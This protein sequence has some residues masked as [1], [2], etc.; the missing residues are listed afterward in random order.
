MDLKSWTAL[1]LA[2]LGSGL[3]SAQQA[4]V[5]PRRAAL[6]EFSDAIE[7]LA[8][9]ASPAVV[10]LTVRGRGPVEDGSAKQA[11]FVAEQRATGSGVI[12]D[13]AGYIMTNAHVV[14]EARSIDVSMIVAGAGARPGDHKH[15]PGQLVGIDPE[16]DLALVKVDG[17]GFPTLSFAD[18]T[19][20][21]Q[22]QLVMAIG[23]PLGLDNT[24]TVGYISAPVRHLDPVKPMFYIQTDAAINPGNSGG[25]L[26]DLQGRLVGINTMIMTQSGGSEGLGFAIPG[27]IVRRVY[28]GLRRDGTIKRGAIGVIPQ[29]ISPALATALGLDHDSGVILSD[30]VPHGAAEAAGLQPG[31]MVLAVDGHP[32]REAR[33]LAAMV[34][35]RSFGEEMKLDIQRGKGKMTVPVVVLRKDK[36]RADLAELVSRDAQLVRR[37][38]ILALPLD[39]KV[40]PI[41]PDLRRL[42]GVVVAAI[43]VEYAAFNPGLVTGDVIY[44][45]NTARVASLDELT[46]VLNAKKTGDAIALLVERAGQLI[47]VAFELE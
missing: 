1:A 2:L 27:N 22:G 14:R 5:S 24:V 12:V 17:H 15:Y 30:I 33:E 34:F 46:S 44:E 37:L 38:G 36:G 41:L 25:A 26:L 28:Q 29:D 10:Q 39:D 42:N 19:T 31:D 3:L 7:E 32:L 21:R 23:S 18:S 8:R 20:L 43:P 35:Q 47:Y 11:G 13:S 40:T 4:A 9:T 6:I 16:T 45:V